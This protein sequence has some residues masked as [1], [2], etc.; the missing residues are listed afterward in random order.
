M[1]DAPG[2]LFPADVEVHV[3]AC[4][5]TIVRDGAETREP[6]NSPEAATGEG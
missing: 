3:L 4:D 6:I 5:G 1:W 2:G